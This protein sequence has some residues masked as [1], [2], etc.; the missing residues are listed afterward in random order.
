[1]LVLTQLV[2]GRP[3]TGVV[4]RMPKGTKMPSKGVWLLMK[5]LKYSHIFSF[6]SSFLNAQ[7]IFSLVDVT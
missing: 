5:I 1:M 3:K 6:P 2:C 4:S 7:E